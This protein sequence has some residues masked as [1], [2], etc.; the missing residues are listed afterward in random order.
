M[1]DTFASRKSRGSAAIE[2]AIFLPVLILLL[3]GT[4]EIARITYTYYTLHK[5][6]YALARYVSTQQGAN[7]CD[8]ADPAVV[9]AKSFALNGTTD[10]SGTAI[11]SD[12]TADMISI[13]L[14]QVD[15]ASGAINECACAVPGC[16][17]SNGGLP[18]DY[19]VVSLPNGYSVTPHI[20]LI[21]T[22]P[23]ALRP[24]VRL[25]YGGT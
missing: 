7:L 4:L 8:T 24:Q 6:M 16:D 10:N 5:M 23:I 25:P 1:T 17:T 11:L 9:A 13:R 12:L 19:I 20:P 2:A 3:M 14:E 22:N 18:P 21:P 15:A